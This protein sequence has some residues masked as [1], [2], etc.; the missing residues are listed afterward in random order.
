MHFE[1]AGGGGGCS[2]AKLCPTLCNPMNSSTPGFSS[3]E[4]LLKC[5]EAKACSPEVLCKD[6]VGGPWGSVDLIH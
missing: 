2:V 5:V 6:L 3:Q 1:F 4:S